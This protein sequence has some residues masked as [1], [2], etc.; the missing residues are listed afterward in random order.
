MHGFHQLHSIKFDHIVAIDLGKFNSVVCIYDPATTRHS[1]VTI[2]TIPQVVHDFLAEHAG[3]D[4]AQTLVVFE[5]CDCGG[6]V[7]DIAVALGFVVAIANPSHEAWRWTK[8]KRKTDR[9]DALKLASMAAMR[10]LPTVHMP[11]PQQ[12]QKRRLIHQRR[13]LVQRR[14]EVKNSI[15]SI[16]SQQGLLLVRGNKQW[17]QAGIA[18]LKSE[19]KPLGKCSVDELWRGRLHVELE[20]LDVLDE[21]LKIVDRKLDGLG[22]ED[23]RIER[24]QQVKGVG[25]RLAEALVAHIDDPHRFKSAR[26]VSAYVGLVPRQFESG[27]MKRVGRI[28]RRG[29]S[30]LRG[31]LIEVAWMVY[32]HN[33]WAKRFVNNVSRGMKQ[34]K[35]IAIVALARKLL[36]RLW[37]MLRDGSNWEDPDRRKN[38][39]EDGGVPPAGV[40]APPACDELSRVEDTARVT[41]LSSVGVA[42]G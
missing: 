16:F 34:R 30:L 41:A 28:T 23:K 4:P 15:R 10:Q 14:T 17:T 22:S 21:Q 36:V 9:D 35:K 20:L 11:S 26:Q 18:Q 13:S 19:S 38:K 39:G 33:A 8:V 7:Y 31:M 29:P 32:R 25:P 42:I 2:Q 1:F 6:W 24:L 37:A 12:R 5:T 40:W 27:T 3:E